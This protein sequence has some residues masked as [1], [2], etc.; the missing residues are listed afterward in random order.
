MFRIEAELNSR[1]NECAKR[2]GLK[3]YDLALMALKAAV[4]VIEE[5]EYRLVVPI[6][7][8]AERVPAPAQYP[9]HRPQYSVT[10]DRP[11]SEPSA[12]TQRKVIQALEKDVAKLRAARAPA[13]PERKPKP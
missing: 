11:S 7:F 8:K 9:K 2:L 4:E 6:Q 10:E 13:P 5:N 3:K 12:D 1:L